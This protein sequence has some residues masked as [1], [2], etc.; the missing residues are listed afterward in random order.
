MSRITFESKIKH[1]FGK[2]VKR[3]TQTD[4]GLFVAVLT[5]GIRITGTM[6]SRKF[7]VRWGSGHQAQFAF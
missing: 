6:S 3:I 5:E 2:A 1:R 7:T 4:Q